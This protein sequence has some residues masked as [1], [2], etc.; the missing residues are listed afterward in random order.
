MNNERE[1][2]L[3]STIY[4]ACRRWRGI[5]IF[6]IVC[7]L[8]IGAFKTTVGF[9]A[10]YDPEK[11]EEEEA[12]FKI[13]Y[14]NYISTGELLQATYDSLTY[15]KL[16]QQEYNDRSV[17]MK[18]DT[19]DEWVGKL[20]MY[21]DSGYQIIPE[22]TYQDTD[23]TRRILS[24]Y[25][26]YYS[27]GDLFNYVLDHSSIASERKYLSE[28]LS[29]S[30]NYDTAT[31]N[32]TSYGTNENNSRSIIDLVKTYYGSKYDTTV[33]AV[34]DHTCRILSETYYTQVNEGLRDTQIENRNRVNNLTVSIAENRD[35]YEDWEREGE[36]RPEY[37]RKAVL[38]TAIKYMIIAG[39]ACVFVALC[40][41]ICLEIFTR[42]ISGEEVW[43]IYNVRLLGT[44]YAPKRFK[45]FLKIDKLINK[46]FGIKEATID[47]A[48]AVGLLSANVAGIL[49]ENSVS[50]D[51]AAGHGSTTKIAVISTLKDEYAL[52]VCRGIGDT[53]F[54]GDIL[55][56]KEAIEKVGASDSVIVVARDG[57]TSYEEI[58]RQLDCLKGW[59]K[60]VLGAVS[61]RQAF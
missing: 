32:V 15:D 18:I 4:S 50:S 56:E 55:S 28:I 29:V 46:L 41:F 19:N 47:T 38:K 51:N 61:I 43:R 6:S 12:K 37:G 48:E 31:I 59:G 44:V 5:L 49:K 30:V 10:Y 58:K 2:D 1:I 53:V 40:W 21:V 16:S 22:L 36:P 7:A 25:E 13:K 39:V 3:L 27:N 42:R 17:L 52:N 60:D 33:A 8:I 34:A 23:P 9:I 24:T 26:Q 20:T 54:V 11:R 45:S 14:D 35:A 57:E